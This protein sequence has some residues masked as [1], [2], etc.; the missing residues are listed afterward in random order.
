[1]TRAAI[2]AR[3]SS[4][5]QRDASIED[6]VELCRRGSEVG[7]HRVTVTE[8]VVEFLV[9]LRARLNAA[10]QDGHE[11]PAI[12]WPQKRRFVV[13]GAGA[14]VLGWVRPAVA[15]NGGFITTTVG[16]G[17]T[18]KRERSESMTAI[19]GK[20]AA[21]WFGLVRSFEVFQGLER[22]RYGTNYFIKKAP[23]L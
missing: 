17:V 14:G 6:Q 10:A 2:Y 7:L 4:D 9:D 21:G 19:C 12:G 18:N 13:G 3:Y 20:F 23:G 11:A 1:M 5:N 8:A 16:K 22:A 15:E